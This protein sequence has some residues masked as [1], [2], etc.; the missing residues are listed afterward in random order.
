MICVS[1]VWLRRLQEELWLWLAPGRDMLMGEEAKFF[2]G[3]DLVRSNTPQTP[4]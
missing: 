2:N 3:Q 4:V 1:V